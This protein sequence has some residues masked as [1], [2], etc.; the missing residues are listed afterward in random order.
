MNQQQFEG[1]GHIGLQGVQHSTISI[2]Q[3]IGHSVEYE[4]LS[5]RLQEL[6]EMQELVPG[7]QTEK[8]EQLAGKIALQQQ[9]IKTFKEDVLRLAR[10]F[11]NITLSTD[12]LRKAKEL[13]D[14]G[15]F[16]EADAVFNAADLQK[17]Q[18]QLLQQQEQLS[19]ALRNNANSYLV[20][21]QSTALDYQ[22][23]E[24]FTL[25]CTYFEQSLKA[26]KN[27]DNMGAY[28]K[29]LEAHKMSSRARTYCEE[30][31]DM[32]R[33]HGGETLANC[34]YHL[35]LAQYYCNRLN[36]AR[37][38]WTE[39]TRLYSEL[40]LQHP[41]QYRVA[42]MT[43]QA[44][45]GRL[46][47]STKRWQEAVN[48]YGEQLKEY[49]ALEQQYPGKFS[50]DITLTRY[51]LLLARSENEPWADIQPQLYELLE[52]YKQQ[53]G[54]DPVQYNSFIA[55]LYYNISIKHQENNQEEQALTAVTE[56][57]NLCREVLPKNREAILPVLGRYETNR[58]NILYNLMRYEDA[59]KNYREAEEI[60]TVC[61]KSEPE[62][63]DG[64]YVQTVVGIARTA[65]KVKLY[66]YSGE[67]F[68]SALGLFSKLAEKNPAQYRQRYANTLYDFGRLY[69]TLGKEEE[70]IKQYTLALEQYRQCDTISEE[71]RV[72]EESECMHALGVSS[73][74]IKKYDEAVQYFE[75]CA[76]RRRVLAKQ[77][78][79]EH[80]YALGLSLYNLA[81]YYTFTEPDWEKAYPYI[82][83]IVS[84][85][86][87]YALPQESG[88]L[89]DLITD[90]AVLLLT[91]K[92]R[93]E[94]AK[95]AG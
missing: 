62:A 12:A 3:Y 17:E 92:K 88:P 70:A 93:R 23:P 28:I 15:L 89:F 94:E 26:H 81:T 31:V 72:K 14:R 64:D 76:V 71:E 79:P 67:Q 40:Y 45:N 50:S 4:Q 30:A 82:D 46:A 39:A 85:N 75:E 73:F 84:K 56:A 69:A 51:N 36:D 9:L 37:S 86:K 25:A 10:T 48:I 80:F 54:N 16:R 1:I 19:E 24:R 47:F 21:A 59:L 41:E 29:F 8:K 53:P 95:H 60:L 20:K 34:L 57:I 13:F 6:Q 22:N 49:Q 33:K 66:E 38:S 42:K 68:T 7:A 83:E 61:R 87:E 65:E 90:T 44:E 18:E 74:N 5:Q 91:W 35:G 55:G 63:F 52:T 43:M 32:A 11:S 58:A 78:P 27:L 2:Q 77:N